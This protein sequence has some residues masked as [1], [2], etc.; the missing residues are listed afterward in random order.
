MKDEG[1]MPWKT[2]FFAFPSSETLLEQSAPL[3]SNET[4]KTMTS[5]GTNSSAPSPQ[6]PTLT[7]SPILTPQQ[8]LELS[9]EL[10]ARGLSVRF[11]A[12]GWSMHPTIDDGEVITVEPIEASEVKKGDIILYR[13]NEGVIAHRVVGIQKSGRAEDRLIL[14]GDASRVPD[15]PVA[16]EQVL[17]KVVSVER[18]GRHVNPY[19]RKS[20][21]V[22]TGHT[23]AS[24]V[25]RGIIRISH[26]LRGRYP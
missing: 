15:R 16:P 8:L 7:H 22:R 21:I 25:K 9:T 1:L 24:R 5:Q 12:P 14:R 20:K 13:I 26:S 23:W 10:F 18:R 17:G 3:A 11:R 2:V 19:S 4:C 6:S